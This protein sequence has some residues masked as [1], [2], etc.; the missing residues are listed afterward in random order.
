MGRKKR[1]TRR[2]QYG[3]LCWP[4]GAHLPWV[5]REA[6]MI[7]QNDIDLAAGLRVK[8]PQR[9]S[10]KQR[11]LVRLGFLSLAIVVPV[12]WSLGEL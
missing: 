12:T 1:R 9:E 5:T 7:V 2:Y 6:W 8:R 4:S 10:L 11:C 3:S